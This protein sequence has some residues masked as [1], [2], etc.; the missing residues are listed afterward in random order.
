ML[1]VAAHSKKPSAHKL[2]TS[3]GGCKKFVEYDYVLPN[4]V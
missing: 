2:N 1:V 3:L 4:A